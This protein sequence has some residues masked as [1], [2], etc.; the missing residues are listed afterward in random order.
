MADSVGHDGAAAA[1]SA[2]GEVCTIASGGSAMGKIEP[3]Q[4]VA[5]RA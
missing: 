5:A 2:T 4:P 1:D 3:A